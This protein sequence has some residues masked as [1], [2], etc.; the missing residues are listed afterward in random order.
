MWRAPHFEHTHTRP[1]YLASRT[2]QLVSRQLWFCLVYLDWLTLRFPARDFICEKG[3]LMITTDDM[4][5]KYWVDKGG[6]FIHTPFLN[7]CCLGLSLPAYTERL[8]HTGLL[9]LHCLNVFTIIAAIKQIPGSKI[10]LDCLLHPPPG[11]CI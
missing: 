4:C 11:F 2:A 3:S 5:L 9:K 1:H 8:L 7:V 6:F 10:S